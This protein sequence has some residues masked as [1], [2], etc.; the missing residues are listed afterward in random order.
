M[1]KEETLCWFCQRSMPDLK[2]GCSWAKWFRPVKGWTAEERDL[3]LQ[4]ING[5]RRMT[6]SYHV[7]DCPL[8]LPDDN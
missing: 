5:Q 2:I 3:L 4:V 8:F 6:K 7:I 1:K